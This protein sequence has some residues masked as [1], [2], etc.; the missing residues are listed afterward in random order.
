MSKKYKIVLAA[1]LILVL[2]FFAF[3]VIQKETLIGKGTEVLLRLAPVDPR[4]LM[5][6][7]YMALDFEVTRKISYDS[8]SG[9]VVVKVGDDRV[10]EFV[11]IQDG[12]GVNNGEF[13]IRYKR[14]NGRLTIGADNYF[15][16]E[17][18]AKKFENAK[19]GLLKVDSDGNSI[20]VGLCD[21]DGRL[22]E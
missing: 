8:K 21:K 4:S 7:D 1:N 5:Q 18:S 19:Y 3:S 20:L 15:F 9:Y 6:G 10:A 22:I 12:K 2:A 11:R 16:Q 17:G 13:I 14:H